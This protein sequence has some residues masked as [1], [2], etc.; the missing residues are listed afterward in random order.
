MRL[1]PIILALLLMYLQAPLW[2]G[3]GG[4]LDSQEMSRRISKVVSRNGELIERNSFLKKEVSD[5]RNGTH[6]I[7]ERARKDMGMI[8]SDEIF[9]Q[10]TK[11]SK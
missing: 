6:S 9:V 10:I 8:K 1:V 4:W 5:L 2:F 3:K 7:E 11:P